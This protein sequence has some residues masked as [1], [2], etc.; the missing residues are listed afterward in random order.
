MNH[1]DPG[2][3]TE[4]FKL[5]KTSVAPLRFMWAWFKPYCNR[6]A[7]VDIRSSTVSMSVGIRG[8]P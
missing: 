1:A 5:F 4:V 6:D 8:D 2:T 3:A 7:T